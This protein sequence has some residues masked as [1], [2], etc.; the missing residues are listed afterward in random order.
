MTTDNERRKKLV[1]WLDKLL[2]QLRSLMV[3]TY[4]KAI[5]EL[6]DRI[7]AGEDFVWKEDGTQEKRIMDL[8]KT[9]QGKINLLI[10]SGVSNFYAEGL[11]DAADQIN[12][13]LEN[14]KFKF[15]KERLKDLKVSATESRRQEAVA[16]HAETVSYR[17]GAMNN[18]SNRVW[19]FKKQ[20]KEEIEQIVQTAISK[21]QGVQEAKNSVKE[22]LN[23]DENGE[24]KHGGKPGVYK[25]PEKNC[26]RLI[27]TETTAA[28]RRA[29]I[30]IYQKSNMVLGFEIHLSGNHYTKRGKKE[31]KPLHDICDELA[32]IYPKDFYWT[33]W[34]PNCRCYITPVTMTPDQFGKYLDAK[35]AGKVD[36][37][38]D[39]IRVKDYPDNFKKYFASH[40][41][42][43]AK[44]PPQW[45][46]NNTSTLPK[47]PQNSEQK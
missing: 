7:A 23:T 43:L 26:E 12:K 41:D 27:R 31:P 46:K 35:K 44:N 38:L 36:E 33:G 14:D 17:G 45:V 9:L 13:A 20:A 6:R 29:E 4:F 40:A 30:D 11:A 25:K 47:L 1:K 22:F 24:M 16:G 37:Y 2:K 34:H 15:K 21:G 42:K 39:S 8:L 19:D 5:E 28:Y 10:A 3:A 32:G 18:L